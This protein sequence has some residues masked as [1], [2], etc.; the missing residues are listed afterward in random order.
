[1][2]EYGSYPAAKIQKIRITCYSF[3][4]FLRLSV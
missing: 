3:A 1:M 2:F 4:D